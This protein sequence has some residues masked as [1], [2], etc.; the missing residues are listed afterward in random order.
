MKGIYKYTDLKTGEIAYVGK[1]SHIDKNT[2]HY[3]HLK[4][5]KYDDQQINKV[6]QN[7]LNRYEYSIL[8]CSDD[9]SE[10]DLN[11]LE[12]SFIERYNPRFNFTKGGEGISG[13]K[14]SEE[15]KRK[16][17]EGNKGKIIS[18]ET[19]RKMSENHADFSGENH[20]LYKKKHSN[21]SKMKMSKAH[22]T[23]GYYRV[24]KH[25]CKRCKQGFTWEYCYYENGKYIKITS[26]DLK[27]LEE[28]ILAKGLEWKKIK[29]E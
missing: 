25:K 4:P 5:S 14:H 18:E 13:Y 15:T 11:M 16:I 8:Y 19:K 1:D 27:K 17:C 12:M 22:N 23:T 21:E 24:S 9:V 7:N 10:D 29:G 20:P 3:A 26:V 2:R 28:K 6:L